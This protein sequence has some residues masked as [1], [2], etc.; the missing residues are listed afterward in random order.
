MTHG[1]VK[2]DDD[3]YH[4][5]MIEWTPQYIVY[6][7]DDQELRRLDQLNDGLVH[8]MN[9][10]LSLFPFDSPDEV[11]DGPFY[12]AFDWFEYYSYD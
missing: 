3:E 6:S 11:G 2:V 4:K 1:N 9:L 7:I 5:Y 10:V 8:N 12:T